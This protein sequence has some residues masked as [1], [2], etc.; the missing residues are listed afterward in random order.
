MR[1]DAQPSESTDE[2]DSS[3]D[4]ETDSEESDSDYV[5]ATDSSSASS[6]E[7]EEEQTEETRRAEREARELERQR[8]LEAAGFI[9]KSDKKP[10]PRPVRTRS[11]KKRRPPPAIPDRA[12]GADSPT[13]QEQ[14]QADNSLRLDHAY[15]RYEAFKQMRANQNRLSVAS[16][17][18]SPSLSS[19]TAPSS[20]TPGTPVVDTESRHSG[21]L[22]FFRSKTP[23]EAEPRTMP[24]ISAPI[25][26]K[27]DSGLNEDEQEAAF[28][29][30]SPTASGS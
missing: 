15:E 26:I 20:T 5:T 28:G 3:D 22:S 17:D 16:L 4:D 7:D 14:E 25:L 27:K 8:V 6:D 9:F 12:A 1:P 2:D 30:V 11:S 13:T 23:S 18:S 29:M 21:F 19:A 24:V 10:P